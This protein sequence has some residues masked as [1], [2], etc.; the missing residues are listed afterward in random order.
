MDAWRTSCP[1]LPIWEDTRDNG[2]VHTEHENGSVTVRLTPA[3]RSFLARERPN[4]APAAALS[5]SA[6]PA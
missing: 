5:P 1:R 2:F 3:G 6:P 4:G